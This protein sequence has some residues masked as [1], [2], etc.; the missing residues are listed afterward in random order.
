[1]HDAQ[2]SAVGNTRRRVIPTLL[3]VITTVSYAQ[4]PLPPLPEPADPPLAVPLVAPTTE[5]VPPTI[6]TTSGG[7]VLAGGAHRSA[8]AI[9][10]SGFPTSAGKT[11]TTFAVDNFGAATYRVPIWTPPGVGG[12]QLDLSLDYSS[13]GPDG[14]TGLGWSLSGL[15]SIARCHHTY[16]QDGAPQGVV[17]AQTDRVCL[18]GQQLKLTDGTAPNYVVAG[19]TFGTELETFS[20]V[21]AV[22]SGANVTSFTVKAKN[23]V[24]YTYGATSD[25]LV[26]AGS[27]GTVRAWLLSKIQDPAGNYVSIV[28]QNNSTTGAGYRVDHINYPTIASGAGPYYTVQFNYGA[29][30]A[31]DTLS[32]YVAGF[33][34]IETQQLN[35]VTVSNYGAT[36]PIKQYNLGY[37]TS[38]SSGRLTLTS[39]QEC[40]NASCL[41]PTTIQY[42][43]GTPGWATTKTASAALVSAYGGPWFGDFNG[44]GF[45]DTLV[46]NTLVSTTTDAA[47]CTTKHVKLSYSLGTLSGFGAVL[48]DTGL[49]LDVPNPNTCATPF[50]PPVVGR[51]AGA[52]RDQ[53]LV[54][55]NGYWAILDYGS[56][57]FSPL[58][59][60]NLAS[61][62]AYV[63]ADVDGDGLADLV[64]INGS[65]VQV[66]RNTTTVGSSVTFAPAAPV[67]TVAS[68]VTLL[69]SQWPPTITKQADF[70]GDGR[71]DVVVCSTNVCDLLFSNGVGSSG[72]VLAFS[73]FAA[74]ATW[75]SLDTLD[76]NGDGCTDLMDTVAGGSLHLYISNC[77]GGFT[78]YTL[79]AAVK[80]YSFGRY[81]LQ[82]VVPIDWDGDGRSDILYLDTAGSYTFQVLQ[83]N[84]GDP[85]LAQT[86]STG[87]SHDAV[88]SIPVPVGFVGLDVFADGRQSLIVPA[89]DSTAGYLPRLGNALREDVAS[90]FTDGLGMSQSVSYAPLSSSSIYSK[91]TTAVFPEADYVGPYYAVTQVTKMDGTAASTSTLS[92][93]QLQYYYYGA[94]QHV[95]GRGFEGFYAV[96][97]LDSRNNLSTYTY[98][99]QTFPYTG[100]VKAV[101]SLAPGSIPV[102]S[103]AGTPSVTSLTTSGVGGSFEGRYFRYLQDK[104]TYRFESG[105]YKN[106]NTVGTEYTT[107]HYDAYG[108]PDRVSTTYTDGD[109][110]APVSP[111]NGQQWNTT[112]ATT[113]NLDTANGCLDKPL[114]QTTTWTNPGS[115]ATTLTQSYQVDGP[116]CRVTNK[117]DQPGIAGQQILTTY[118]YD[119]CGGNLSSVQVVGS[120][121]ASGAA[122]NPTPLTRTT[123]YN[124]GYLTSRCQLPE[125]ITDSL[126]NF[127]SRSYNY[128]FGVVLTRKDVNGLSTSYQLDDFGR[129]TRTTRPD[130]TYTTRT[131]NSCNASNSYCGLIDLRFYTLDSDYGSDATF[132][133]NTEQFMDGFGRVRYHESYRPGGI[134]TIDEN[135]GYDSLGRLV[136]RYQP[137]DTN[138]ANGYY[139]YSYDL[140]NRQS[141]W[142]QYDGS[143][144]LYRQGSTAF[145]GSTRVV[146][147]ARGLATTRVSDAMGRL[148]QVQ[149]PAP[150]G[151]TRY[152]Y[153]P[154]GHLNQTIDAIGATSSAVFDVYGHRTSMVDPDAGAWT[155]YPDT[156]G[157]NLAWTDAKG[158]SF[159]QTF[160]AVGH[161]VTRTEPEGTSTWV[162]GT[163]KRNNVASY[164]VEKL[165]SR[166]GYGHAETLFYDSLSRLATKQ[167]TT[168]QT[169]Q[170][171]YTY[172]AWGLLATTAYPTSPIP[173]SPVA[174]TGA[175]F[176]TKMTYGYGDVVQIQDITNG[177]PGPVLWSLGSENSFR[178]PLTETIGYGA[179][180]VGVTSI[181]GKSWTNQLTGL[182]S[183]LASS[184]MAFQKLVYAWDVDDNLTSRTDQNQNLTEVFTPD[185][186]NRV[187]TV[188]LNGVQTLSVTY[189][190]AGDIATKSDVG[191]YAYP[192][193]TAARPHAVTAAGGNS[194]AYDANGNL[195][196]R[197]GL[198]NT[199]A[200][201]NLPTI[202]Q[203]SVG[204]TTL[205]TTL[206]YG[207][208]HA[209]YQQVATEL[210]GTE[211]TEYVGGLLEKVTTSPA[212]GNPTTYWRHYVPTPT[213]QTVIAS[214][215]SDQ[216]YLQSVVLS[217]HLGSTSMVVDDTPGSGAIGSVVFQ[218]SYDAF[219]NRRNSNW[220]AGVPGYWTQ[221]AI[222]ERT[223]HG[224][225]GHEHLDNVGLIH[226]NGRVYDPR[227]GRFLSADPVVVGPGDGQGLNAYSYVRNRPL[228]AVDPTGL[229]E[230]KGD[231]NPSPSADVGT[232]NGELEEVV[233]TGT[234]TTL[235]SSSSTLLTAEDVSGRAPVRTLPTIHVGLSG[236]SENSSEDP[237][238]CSSFCQSQAYD[239]NKDNPAFNNVA[240]TVSGGSTTLTD[241]KYWSPDSFLEVLVQADSEARYQQI[242][243][244]DTRF[245]F[246]WLGLSLTAPVAEIGASVR[247]ALLIRSAGAGAVAAK[248][249][250]KVAEKI[251]GYTRHGI[252]QAISREG[253]GVSPRAILDAVRNPTSVGEQ[254]NGTI[255]YVG[256]DATVILNQEGKVVTTYSRGAAGTRVPVPEPGGGP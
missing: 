17:L 75:S 50:A 188:T 227:I 186:L 128:D 147:D 215:G 172:N 187:S 241:P 243:D 156:F 202:L 36:T 5:P 41:T 118:G 192:A 113:F 26:M 200:S 169:Y 53:I 74:P 85:A 35:S 8:A 37:S 63:L 7:G 11:P 82:R 68:G 140:L 220:S 130:G 51:L 58:Q 184:P 150:G 183:G 121:P 6:P 233:V 166:T 39:I 181:Y 92:A 71:A 15:S 195:K 40:S 61:N 129:T 137:Y 86:K 253:V 14:R 185:N 27:S 97:V 204:G 60:T 158:Q 168:D 100:Q 211:T 250:A 94:R 254:A 218:E 43:S 13:Q 24:V 20:T 144:N 226:M 123:Y 155:F 119:S 25:A 42:Q 157:E 236:I 146:Y 90:S 102:R 139:Q 232:S 38:A 21:T 234:R 70:N 198:N 212:G 171:D 180:A 19:N 65:T 194:Y 52:A 240:T 18:D 3:L 104:T 178:S 69:S 12:A 28:Y 159:S 245:M 141:A 78:T 67:Y 237:S 23:G 22:G 235:E 224:F 79:P 2:R 105:Q 77:A 125:S 182:Q 174:Q 152:A 246:A 95:Q 101:E 132:I 179:G 136:K 30:P 135:S 122:G 99:G 165:V 45:P 31:T 256:K 205:T 64:G 238:L 151:L 109:S 207:P 196:T 96:R 247:A 131:Y 249:G 208:D 225:T 106:G 153:D 46:A 160:D 73:A 107:F 197:N 142:A 222:A 89:A 4:A 193:A 48:A 223:R 127:E 164:D 54:A 49:V 110:T 167:I 216:T 57:G 229:N 230:E 117:T 244:A 29:R 76:W 111:F 134:W 103:W 145:Q 115:V 213:G 10:T 9:N 34:N 66:M 16:A 59:F 149:E 239:L 177:A 203:A 173:S 124:T 201:F 114:S 251:T 163:G 138:G 84:G 56:A 214:R 219:G 199:W 228:S 175:R 161:R 98:L 88:V 93:Y 210:N 55:V 112:V 170:F 108:N 252:N 32:T 47:G 148:R 191:S 80:N 217:D 189:D 126:G 206:S 242:L 143:G 33:A 162:W 209:R 87:I 221:V 133:T 154:Q 120:L 190:A 231:L 83:S 91:Y 44:D 1:M 176:T 248:S 116:H 72:T 62:V 255:K 81:G